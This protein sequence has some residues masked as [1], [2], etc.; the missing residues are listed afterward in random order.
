MSNFLKKKKVRDAL[1]R[2]KELEGH[3]PMSK[4]QVVQIYKEGI[5]FG[6]KLKDFLKPAWFVKD[7]KVSKSKFKGKSIKKFSKKL[8]KKKIKK[9]TIKKKKSNKKKK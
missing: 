5:S 7:E 9:K 6:E 4:E 2:A 3:Q 8:K 1:R